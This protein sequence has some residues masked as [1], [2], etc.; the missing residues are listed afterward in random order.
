VLE[1]PT[2][3]RLSMRVESIAEPADL[4]DVWRLE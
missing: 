4:E 1:K 3:A 2:S